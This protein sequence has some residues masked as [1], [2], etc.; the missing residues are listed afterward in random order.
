MGA[1][2]KRTTE[3]LTLDEKMKAVTLHEKK[4]EMLPDDVGKREKAL[5]Q[6]TKDEIEKILTWGK[7]LLSSPDFLKAKMTDDGISLSFKIKNTSGL[8]FEYIRIPIMLYGVD[9]RFLEQIIFQKDNW[10]NGKVRESQR[11]LACGV[12]AR[13]S[14]DFRNIVY[15][16]VQPELPEDAVAGIEFNLFEEFMDNNSFDIEVEPMDIP[17]ASSKD[18]GDSAGHSDT[19]DVKT[20]PEKTPENKVKEPVKKPKGLTSG[21]MALLVLI[22]I[23]AG[24]AGIVVSVKAS[25]AHDRAERIWKRQFNDDY[26]WDPSLV[27]GIDPS[28]Y[29]DLSK[30]EQLVVDY[31]IL[32][33]IAEEKDGMIEDYTSLTDADY[34]RAVKQYL[35]FSKGGLKTRKNEILEDFDK[36]VGKSNQYDLEYIH[37]DIDDKDYEQMA[38]KFLT[39]VPIKDHSMDNFFIEIADNVYKDEM[40]DGCA[41]IIADSETGNSEVRSYSN[42]ARAYLQHAGVKSIPNAIAKAKETMADEKAAEEAEIQRINEGLAELDKKT[43]GSSASTDSSTGSSGSS[44]SGSVSGSGSFSGGSSGRWKPNSG[45]GTGGSG[46]IY[47]SGSGSGSGSFGAGSGSTPKT[48]PNGWADYDEGYDD[49][50]YN[51]EYD[52]ERYE[53]DPEYASGVDDARDEYEEVYGEEFD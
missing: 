32:L 40:I 50:M 51:D 37:W 6:N 1:K 43:S 18:V 48:N 52:E 27:K 34:D 3:Y 20:E 5:L 10:P 38:I 36:I 21:M 41:R 25:T 15:L 42:R 29:N 30:E 23:A 19:D 9:G 13:G 31:K 17:S 53:T 4:L 8:D 47:N 12:P 49:V 7:E 26:S 11:L 35:R 33:M 44:G 39:T 14:V 16:A 2:E 46:T 45:S 22:I 28:N 24:I